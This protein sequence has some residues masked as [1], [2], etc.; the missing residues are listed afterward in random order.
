MN[1]RNRISILLVMALLGCGS[2][3]AENTRKAPAAGQRPP[4]EVAVITVQPGHAEIFREY[5]GRLRASRTAEVRA[6]I[7]G[8]VHK[9]LFE[10][11]GRVAAGQPLFR[12]EDTIYR[13]ALEAARAELTAAKRDLARTR[14]LVDKKLAAPEALDAARARFKRSGAQL[15]RARQD[16]DNTL[17]PAPI[18]GRIGRA[19]VTEG[20]LVGRGEA[21]LLAVIEQLDPLYV[22]FQRN[23]SELARL[24]KIYRDAR[25]LPVEAPEVEIV[26]GEGQRLPARLLFGERR[27]DPATGTVLMRARLDNPK[28][29]HLPGAFVRVRLPVLH[30]ARILRVPQRAVQA[31]GKGLQVLVVGPDGKAMPK[32]IVAPDMDGA[33]FLVTQGLQPGERVIVEG[34]QKVRPGATVKAVPWQAASAAAAD[35]PARH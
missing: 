3:L 15:A 13:T 8:I 26:L 24:V 34:L 32:P 29:K 19:R 17:V 2:A 33:D 5:P 7:E 4:V 16:L 18:A 30:L 28:E 27:V 6:R 10:E 14:E 12:I 1:T 23:A 35:N 9:R 21:T 25:P 31:S 22:D 20:A 11:G